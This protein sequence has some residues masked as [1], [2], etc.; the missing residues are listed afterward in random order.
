VRVTRPTLAGMAAAAVVALGLTA[1]CARAEPRMPAPALADGGDQAAGRRAVIEQGCGGCHRVP[2]IPTADAL[3]GPP[4]DSWSQ[5]SF[6]A[7]TLPNSAENLR[8]WL[9]DPQ[10]VRPGSAMP[11]LGLDPTEIADI[12]AFLFSLD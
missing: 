8:I 9:E 10:Q 2:G 4:L 3:V 7:G 12:V 5:R 11:N 1:S 6:I